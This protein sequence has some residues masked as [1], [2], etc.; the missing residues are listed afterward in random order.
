M[1]LGDNYEAEEV[2]DEHDPFWV[3]PRSQ[4][5]LE[6][7]ADMDKVGGEDTGRT[8]MYSVYQGFYDGEHRVALL[9]RAADYLEHVSGIKYAD[10]VCD[11]VVDA[12]ADRLKIKGWGANP[13]AEGVTD[14][15]VQVWNDN[16]LDETFKTATVQAIAKGDG[17]LILDWEPG[18]YD[19]NGE[20]IPGTGNVC[21]HFN[22]PDKV[23]VEYDPAN[24]QR[25]RLAVKRWTQDGLERMNVYTEGHVER[26]Y[27]VDTDGEWLP[28][29]D[30]TSMWPVPWTRD[31]TPGGKPRGIP[32]FHL[33]NKPRGKS[34]GRSEIHKVIPQQN[35]LNKLFLDLFEVADQQGF[36]QRWATGITDSESSTLTS[37]VGTVWTMLDGQGR[38]GQ[39]EA[40]NLDQLVRT[41][42]FRLQVIAGLSQTPVHMLIL[43][44]AAPSGEALKASE[45]GLTEKCKDRQPVFGHVWESIMLM[46]LH[47]LADNGHT[48]TGL[49]D[50]TKLVA[51][52]D[53]PERTPTREAVEVG[54]MKKELGVSTKTILTELGYENVEDELEQ[55]A[56]EAQ[57]A[58]ELNQ[59]AMTRGLLPGEAQ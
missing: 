34:Y 2:S 55:S 7:L 26:Y 22:E 19:S 46:S 5:E 4:E 8:A 20:Q 39:F 41:I 18:E 6:E 21:I 33:R 28:Y 24:P 16:N 32:V 27:S 29:M 37:G 51:V 38:F 45:A 15:T 47:L 53:N 42:E 50:D 52:W 44:G 57:E 54:L 36:P 3:A 49:G 35:A 30:D 56:L 31:N 11:L 12:M 40:A 25:K 13:D 58:L 59:Q 43:T 17:F 14:A 1:E 10:N 23:K 48:V 9:D